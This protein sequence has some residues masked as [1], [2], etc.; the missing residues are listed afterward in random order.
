M[1]RDLELSY[2]PDQKP[3]AKGSVA[4]TTGFGDRKKSNFFEFTAFGK[5]A[6]A[7]HKYCS[8]GDPIY[9]GG[10]LEQQ[11]WQAQDGSNRQRVTVII[12]DFQFLKAKEAGPGEHEYYDKPTFYEPAQT[13]DD[14]IPF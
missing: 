4:I 13:P 11:R 8:K 7:L 9:L 5:R 2:T 3:I 10:R 6:E 14:E 12:E 1:A